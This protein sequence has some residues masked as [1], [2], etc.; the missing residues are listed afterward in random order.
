M[1][2]NTD[3]EHLVQLTREAIENAETNGYPTDGMTD[4]ELA[5][6][7]WLKA[8]FV[9]GYAVEYLE[10]LVVDARKGEHHG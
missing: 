6:D 5:E 1:Q 8:D 2:S 9:E 7:L 4:R 10:E 3:H